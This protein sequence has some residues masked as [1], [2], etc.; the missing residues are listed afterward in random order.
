MRASPSVEPQQSARSARPA[1]SFF[2]AL[3]AGILGAIGIASCCLFP[4]VFLSV[5]LGGAWLS[6]LAFFRNYKPVLVIVTG[7][8]LAYGYYSIYERATDACCND[9]GC[10]QVRNTR[11]TKYLLWTIT[12]LAAAG[13][14]IEYIE[15]YLF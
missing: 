10:P 8:A 9:G 1:R 5:G 4:I 2:L 15:P 6:N 14:A 7:L 13:L 12:L 3:S 11:L